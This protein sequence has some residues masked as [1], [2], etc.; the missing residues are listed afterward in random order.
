MDA[1]IVGDSL[2]FSVY[3]KGFPCN[4]KGSPEA[5]EPGEPVGSKP[6]LPVFFFSPLFFLE[7][8]HCVP[9]EWSL[10]LFAF[11]SDVFLCEITTHK[12]LSSPSGPCSDGTS[13]EGGL[14]CA[15]CK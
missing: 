12:L 5:L 11:S 15:H 7:F 2:S 10:H 14:S 9:A 13:S 1:N 4:T 8:C 6:V 3:F